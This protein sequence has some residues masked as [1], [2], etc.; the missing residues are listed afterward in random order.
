LL[1]ENDISCMI[2]VIQ[3]IEEYVLMSSIPYGDFRNI[4]T[5]VEERFVIGNQIEG[6]DEGILIKNSC[7]SLVS[8]IILIILNMK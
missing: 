5:I 3:L 7:L 8:S 1:E 2:V 6:H 4:V